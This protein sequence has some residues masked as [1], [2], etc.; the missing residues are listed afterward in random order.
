MVRVKGGTVSHRRHKKVLGQAK[1]YRN[2]GHR[3]FKH[4]KNKVMLAGQHA[5]R[6]RRNKK[7]T[8]RRLWIARLNAACRMRGMKYSEFIAKMHDKGI[9][10]DRKVLSELA[11][12]SPEAF[13]ALIAKIK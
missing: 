9:L 5:Y 4:A 8:M 7:R 12:K 3:I 2:L 11:I 6:D 10:L 1:G 13:D